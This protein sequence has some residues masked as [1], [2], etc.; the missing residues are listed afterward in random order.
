MIIRILVAA[1]A[2]TATAASAEP[3]AKELFGAKRTASAHKP[4]PIGSYAK[5]C[6]AGAEQLPE[7]DL[8]APRGRRCACPET[9]IG[10]TPKRF[11]S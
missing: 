2:L 1:L 4:A 3:L 7:T 11:R 9:V 5:G 8:P 10:A 6:V